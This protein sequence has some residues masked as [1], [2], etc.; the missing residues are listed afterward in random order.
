MFKKEKREKT[1][2]FDKKNLKVKIK[3]H[4]KIKLFN[5]VREFMLFLNYISKNH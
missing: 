5:Y 1:R 4:I 3:E 2:I